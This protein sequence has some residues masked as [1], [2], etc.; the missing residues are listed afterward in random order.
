MVVA[1]RPSLS[2]VQHGQH[3]HLDA[4]L[5]NEVLVEMYRIMVLARAVDDRGWLLAR[6][7]KAAFVISGHGH[8]ACQVAAAYALRRGYDYFLPYYRDTAVVLAAG[9]TAEEVLLGVLA[10]AADP[11]SGGRQMPSH[12]SY[13]SLNIF[14]ASSPVATQVVH[15]AGVALAAKL[16]R[17]DR[18]T[19]V[20]FGDG[21]TSEGD[22]HEGLNFA[23]VHRLPVVFFCQ[24]NGYAI[25]VPCSKQSP[26]DS[27]AQRA[28]AYGMPGRCVD[29]TD[30]IAVYEAVYEAAERARAGG[31]P[32]LVEA[33]VPRLVSHSSAD[34]DKTYRSADELEACSRLDPLPLFRSY[35]INAGVLSEDQESQ[36]QSRVAAEVDEAT[37]RA[38]RSPLPQ[39]EDALRPVYGGEEVRK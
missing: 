39:P 1:R 24:N 2:R 27:V 6:Q 22:F 3:R 36:I 21:A 8:E 12:W 25:S 32:S 28:A 37:L 10:R 33:K 23:G 38:E 16:R 5:S 7:G 14:T 4:G 35:L 34:D 11:C 18:V 9:M 26:I 13:P 19:Y 15:A 30:V 31:G 20:S 29:G 17:E